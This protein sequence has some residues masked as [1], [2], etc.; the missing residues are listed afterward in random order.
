[1]AVM[2]NCSS[3]ANKRLSYRRGTAWRAMI[4]LSCHVSR[5]I[6]DRKIS[7]CNGDLQV[8]QGHSQWCHSVGHT[9]FPIKLSLH[10]FRDIITYFPIRKNV[11]WPWI[12]YINFRSNLSYVHL[13]I[14]LSIS[15]LHLKCLV[16]PIVK[17]WLG[18]NKI[19][20]KRV[21][22]PWLHPL[23]V[24]CHSMT[25]ILIYSGCIQKFGDSRLSRFRDMI[26]GIK[27]KMGHVKLTMPLLGVVYYP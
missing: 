8:I 9:R 3:Y 26:A 6:K 5:G 12:A 15:T 24:A 13:Y 17:I 14:P 11:T 25:T 23:G 18:K 21:T 22:W 2:D 20:N 4:A 10:R 1:M 19:K 27:L 7:N 16:W